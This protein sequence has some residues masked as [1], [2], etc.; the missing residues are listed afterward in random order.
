MNK[1]QIEGKATRAVG[2]VKEKT[3]E[4]LDD[5]TLEQDGKDDQVSGRVKEVAGKA[6]DVV[7]SVGDKIKDA[8]TDNDKRSR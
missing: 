6:K 2:V 7:D 8:F 1:D 4:A 3:G 5:P